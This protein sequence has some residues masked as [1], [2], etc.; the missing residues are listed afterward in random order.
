MQMAKDRCQPLDYQS[1]ILNWPLRLK[2]ESPPIC[3]SPPIC[4]SNRSVHVFAH[5]SVILAL[6]SSASLQQFTASSASDDYNCY[7]GHICLPAVVHGPN[8]YQICIQLQNE[9]VDAVASDHLKRA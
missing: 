6:V 5:S 4:F 9:N 1:S 3:L 8:N 7:C 2:G